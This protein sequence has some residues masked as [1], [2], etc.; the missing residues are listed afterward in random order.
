MLGDAQ[1]EWKFRKDF[2]TRSLRPAALD[3]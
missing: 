1:H 3:G 2:N